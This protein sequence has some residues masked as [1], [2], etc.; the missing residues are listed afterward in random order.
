MSPV[1][2]KWVSVV[3]Y[4]CAYTNY[5]RTFTFADDVETAM[6]LWTPARESFVTGSMPQAVAWRVL[7]ILF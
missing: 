6:S 2:P 7:K 3:L 5:I 4:V 1:H